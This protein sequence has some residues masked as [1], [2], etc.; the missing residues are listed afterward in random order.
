MKTTI[1]NK[2]IILVLITLAPVCL[3]CGHSSKANDYKTALEKISTIEKIDIQ[4]VT[5]QRGSIQSVAK[6]I[7]TLAPV[8]STSAAAEV[9]G[10]IV[11]FL[12][13]T[14]AVET[15]VNGTAIKRVIGIDIGCDVKEGDVLFEIDPVNYE[16]AVEQTRASLK[17]AEAQ[18]EEYLIRG[19]RE[20]E[21]TQLKANAEQTLAQVKQSKA[22]YERVY[23]LRESNT[24]SQAEFDLAEA[25][26]DIAKAAYKSADS[27]YKL[28]VKG[29][30]EQQIG[31]Y[32]SQIVSAKAQLKIAEEKLSRTKI[33]AKYDATVTR[34]HKDIGDYVNVGT[35]VISYVDNKLLFADVSVPEPIAKA[36]NRSEFSNY[37]DTSRQVKVYVTGFAEPVIGNIDLVNQVIDV[38]S[39]SKRIRITIDN[40]DGRLT[41]GGF[42]RAE[43]PIQSMEDA[44][45]VPKDAVILVDGNHLAYVYSGGKDSGNVQQRRLKVGIMND[46][47]VEVLEGL[48]YGEEVSCQKLSILA[49]GMEVARSAR[50][51]NAINSSSLILSKTDDATG[52]T[53]R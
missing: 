41:P 31:V 49:N 50:R 18:K 3:G 34:R 11:S 1:T 26:F 17:L 40:S 35:P 52:S 21:I 16:L 37:S 12:P 30:N 20:E 6:P 10:R 27:A 48:K 32:D 4:T 47:H 53:Q 2:L 19:R 39:F 24:V 43:I 9:E 14:H 5:V 28:A 13:S 46:T 29:P 42:V 38:D 23:N 36:I 22:E 25:A 7:G 44:L 33:R 15:A 51:N 45:L 8:H